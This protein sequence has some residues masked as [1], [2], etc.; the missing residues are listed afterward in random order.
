[1]TRLHVTTAFGSHVTF[2][3]PEITEAAFGQLA[4]GWAREEG[5]LFPEFLATRLETCQAVRWESE[6]REAA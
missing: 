3:N 1:M 2:E 4:E 6:E 5:R